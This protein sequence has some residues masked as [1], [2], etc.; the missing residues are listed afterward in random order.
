MV[1]FDTVELIYFF[2]QAGEWRG[3]DGGAPKHSEIFGPENFSE[4]LTCVFLCLSTH[5]SEHPVCQKA[6]LGTVV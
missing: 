2:W 1:D 4:S 3:G 5:V 6:H